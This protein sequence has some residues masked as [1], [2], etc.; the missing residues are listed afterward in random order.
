MKTEISSNVL[1]SNWP[2]VVSYRL[3]ERSLI[4]WLLQNRFQN[5]T[6]LIF[7]GIHPPVSTERTCWGQFIFITLSFIVSCLYHISYTMFCN[8]ITSLDSSLE[9]S[10]YHS[11]HLEYMKEGRTYSTMHFN[12]LKYLVYWCIVTKCNLEI[13]IRIH[14][15][16]QY[17]QGSK[18]WT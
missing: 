12:H 6:T 18:H 16:P 17:A 1:R 11:S 10:K 13:G 7:S 2:E 14:L 3:W 15:I 5:T 4:H 9:T 8:L